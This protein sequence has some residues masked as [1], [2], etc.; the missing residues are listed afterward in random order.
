MLYYC[1]LNGNECQYGYCPCFTGNQ[2]K[3]EFG[4]LIVDAVKSYV[5][6]QKSRMSIQELAKHMTANASGVNGY[7]N[8]IIPKEECK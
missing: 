6:E 1:P 5:T 3:D 4:C 8:S 7:F 2:N